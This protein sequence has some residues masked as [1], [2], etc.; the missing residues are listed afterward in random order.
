MNRRDQAVVAVLVLLLVAL[1]GSLAIPGAGPGAVGTPSPSAGA[2]PATP[3][4]Y[5]EGIVGAPASITPLTARSRSERTLVGLI[6]SGLVKLGPDNTLQPDLA[7]SWEVGTGGQV[8]T[9]HLRDGATW[10]DGTPVTAD[11]VVFTIG[12][13]KAGG[14][15]GVVSSSWAEV[16]VNAVDPATVQFTLQTPIAGFLAALTQPLL[17]RHLLDGASLSDLATSPFS[18]HPIG[19]GP[20]ML[21]QL[22]AS[23]AVLVAAPSG[24]AEPSPSGTGPGAGSPAPSPSASASDSQTPTPTPTPLSPGG[25]PATPSASP[26]RSSPATPAASAPPSDSPSPVASAASP[27]PGAS[28][29]RIEIH[30]YDTEA[31]LAAAFRAGEVDAASGVPQTD[32]ATLADVPGAGL[33]RYP[34]T[35]LSVA[36][37]NLRPTHPELRDPNVRLALL[38]A[39]DRAMLVNRVLGGNATRADALV[40]PTSWAFVAAAVPPVLT[41]PTKAEAL[42]KAAGWTKPD[43]G[44]TAP[45]AKVPY[46]LQ[47]LTVTPEANPRLAAV[48]AF[49]RDE[50]TALGFEVN[51]TALPASD[52]AARLRAGTYVAAVVDIA[53]GLEPDLYPLLASTQART[54]GSNLAGYQDTALDALLAAARA[55]ATQAQRIPALKALEANLA[56]AVPILPLVWHDEVV[57]A[58][59]VIGITPRLIVGPGDRFWDVLAW[60]L[61]AAR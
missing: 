49:V 18:S 1:G 39:I 31:A 5:R 6:F 51:L 50:W 36:M 26:N 56:K 16:D 44:W 38:T 20:Y 47:L 43:A 57:V 61:A 45:K 19:S 17:P 52:L 7:S 59:G 22:D 9:F 58:K 24:G 37:L 48:A 27:L 55:P 10:Q 23:M 4:V 46:I 41:S 60:R 34:T 25:S 35:T 13:L 2:S 29:D 28:F 40:P 42:L 14:T 54:G 21:T 53:M 32:S 3:V 30:F 33:L 11:D 15:G 12:A 8:W